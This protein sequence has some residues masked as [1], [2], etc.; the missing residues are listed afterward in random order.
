MKKRI[1]LLFAFFVVPI[2]IFTQ[3]ISDNDFWAFW[4][5]FTIALMKN[6]R[7]IIIHLTNYP[8][9]YIYTTINAPQNFLRVYDV[10]FPK[11]FK[12]EFITQN[13]EKA[14]N[15]YYI[16]C[17]DLKGNILQNKEYNAIQ[18]RFS[19]IFGQWKLVSID[20]VGD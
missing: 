10:V 3:E 15:D 7:Q 19:K 9:Q 8:F 13:L 14:E 1:F 5:K 4:K 18:Y 11:I 12:K 6:D 20:P 16:V 2:T 17:Y